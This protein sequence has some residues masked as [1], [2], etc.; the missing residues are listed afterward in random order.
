MLDITRID[1][2]S[3]AVPELGPQIELLEG[4][5][6]FR[7]RDE[8]VQEEGHHRGVSFHVPGSSGVDWEVL[9][10]YGE[11]SYIQSFLD[12]PLGPG[13][14]HIAIAVRDVLAAVDELRRLGI[15]PWDGGAQEPSGQ[16][17]ETYIHPSR[18]GNGFLFQLFGASAR[19]LSP[20]AD[21][22]P[23]FPPAE[24]TL[25]IKAV[26]HLAHAHPDR[27]ELAAW[28]ERVLGMRVVHRSPE[29]PS[30]DFVTLVLEAPTG[31]MRLE[32]LQPT[33]PESFVQRFIADRGPAMHHV[34]FEVE[35]WGR[36]VAACEHHGVPTFGER[37][38]VTAGARWNEA[39]IHPR[40]TGGV[41]T[42]LFWQERPGIW[43]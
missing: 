5:F 37:E 40:H 11:G 28:Y 42:Q 18:G 29:V 21:R 41:L 10:P 8:W 7:K 22:S 3:V 26:N 30:S 43:I 39:F 12:S 16:R 9:A 20:G 38:G 35:E 27:E 24:H 1:H 2:I 31:Q 36:A 33:R 17:R 34:T 19:V 25:G 4:L 15:D 14:H 32:I 13:L 6:G 23:P